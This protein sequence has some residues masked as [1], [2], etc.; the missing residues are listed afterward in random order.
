[1]K[2]KVKTTPITTKVIEEESVP[3]I[4][5][6]KRYYIIAGAFAEQKNANR[7][8]ARLNKW[9]YNATIVDSGRLLRVSYDS[10]DNKDK[11]TIVLNK[12]KL[13]NPE[14]WLLTK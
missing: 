8:L 7:M 14:A 3:I 10:F 12:I 11:A 2:V 5:S 6:K 1:P 9:N 13:E 4:I